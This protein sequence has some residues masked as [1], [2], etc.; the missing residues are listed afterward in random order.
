M[1]KFEPCF[2][3]V[4]LLEGGYTLHEIKGDRGGMTYA[5]IAR[6]KW[7]SWTGWQEIDA[8]KFDAELTWMVR[9]FYRVHFWDRIKG[10]SIKSQEV[11][12]TVYT[13][14]VN[15]GRRTAVR[16][17]QR[18]CGATPDGVMGDKTLAAINE[19]VQDAKDE[20]IF[21]L[22]F[23]MLKIFRYKDICLNDKRRAQDNIVS[24][25]KFLCGWINRV[26]K[27]LQ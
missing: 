14:A 2:E 6:N 19:M 11:A 13:F 27:G 9:S 18:I 25:E 3:K 4:I 7:P 10:D 17:A 1:A 20:K 23:G 24:N 16:L 21:I 8:G 15:A 22:L 5:G 26:Q 12:F